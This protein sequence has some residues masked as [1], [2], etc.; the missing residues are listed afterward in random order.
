MQL[1]A[2]FVAC[3]KGRNPGHP[4]LQAG[5]QSRRSVIGDATWTKRP[6]VNQTVFFC[7]ISEAPWDILLFQSLDDIVAAWKKFGLT[8]PSHLKRHKILIMRTTLIPWGSPPCADHLPH[9]RIAA[10]GD[11]TR[12]PC[13]RLPEYIQLP[14]LTTPFFSKWWC[15]NLAPIHKSALHSAT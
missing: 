1:M 15:P 14:E 8:E 11:E 6:S 4:T 5:Q 2:F 12:S 7:E 9:A 3:V 13:L 10:H